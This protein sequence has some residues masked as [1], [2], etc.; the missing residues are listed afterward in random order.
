MLSRKKIKIGGETR[1]FEFGMA[2]FMLYEQET[3]K[4]YGQW[5]NEVLQSLS[6]AEQIDQEGEGAANLLSGMRLTPLAEVAW[7]AMRTAAEL[8]EQV[9]SIK[10]L[11]VASWLND[12]NALKSIIV[13]FM[14]SLPSPNTDEAKEQPDEAKK[15]KAKVHPMTK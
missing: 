1:S 5:I 14:Q 12:I 7:Y 3:G 11:Q 10:L 15:K 6:I 8:D 4:P 9:F 2:M 13:A